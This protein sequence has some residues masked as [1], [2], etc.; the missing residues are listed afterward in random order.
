MSSFDWHPGPCDNITCFQSLPLGHYQMSQAHPVYSPSRHSQLGVSLF[1]PLN[2]IPPYSR[3]SLFA[4]LPTEGHLDCFQFLVIM[5][6]V[7]ID[8]SVWLF[9]DVIFWSSW[10]ILRNV[11]DL[12]KI[13]W[14]PLRIENYNI[15]SSLLSSLW[16]HISDI[17]SFCLAWKISFNTDCRASLRDHEDLSWVFSVRM[18]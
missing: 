2:N 5:N 10:K 4:H 17:L 9:V 16:L 8:T 14:G 15:L 13:I 7:A 18:W 3:H 11:I 12:N 1:S 6:K